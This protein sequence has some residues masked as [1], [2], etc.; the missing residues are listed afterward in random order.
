MVNHYLECLDGSV[1]L[2]ELS[3]L[4]I[5]LGMSQVCQGGTYKH[6]LHTML[7]C[8]KKFLKCCVSSLQAKSGNPP[9]VY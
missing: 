3:M 4:A 2:L 9:T 6:Q 7:L 5:I 8:L 1:G